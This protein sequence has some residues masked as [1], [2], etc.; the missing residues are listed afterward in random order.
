MRKKIVWI[1]VILFLLGGCSNQQ[2]FTEKRVIAQWD[3]ET[4]VREPGTIRYESAIEYCD[5][6]WEWRSNDPYAKDADPL[7]GLSRVFSIPEWALDYAGEIFI[8]LYGKSGAHQQYKPLR[9]GFDE[10]SKN[11]TVYFAPN[12]FYLLTN[13]KVI[14]SFS[15][16]TGKVLG[17]EGNMITTPL[18][19]DP[20][21]DRLY[22]N[23]NN[24]E[25]L[26]HCQPIYNEYSQIIIQDAQSALDI[27]SS[28]FRILNEV[29]YYEKNG[30]WKYEPIDVVF[31]Q[32]R[33]R[34]LIGFGV[35][36]LAGGGYNISLDAKTSE[37]LF[38][39]MG[40]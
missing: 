21:M 34:W 20:V 39:W 23:I 19:N 1:F 5:Y 40:E 10:E 36:N 16:E 26:D 7:M 25:M 18:E 6:F 35:R 27:A 31:D 11:W 15:S 3:A 22:W 33:D 17:I 4:F 32:S 2:Q 24:V 38:I 14:I 29:S 13:Q 8:A 28:Y 9:M 12:S 37:A 30:H